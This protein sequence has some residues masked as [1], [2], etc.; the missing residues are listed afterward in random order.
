MPL[1]IRIGI[2]GILMCAA[3]FY[4]FNWAVDSGRSEAIA[5]TIAVNIFVIGELFYLFNCR[6]LRYSMF[7]VGLFSNPLI[8]VGV[9]LMVLAQLAFTYLP[10]M[11]TAFH[12]EPISLVEWGYC[13]GVGVAIYTVVELEKTIQ[14]RFLY[15]KGKD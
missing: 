11:N 15:K 5:H 4:F 6:S 9:V 2:V 8:I 10:F 1:I 3:A 7:K 12:S 14:N 13:V